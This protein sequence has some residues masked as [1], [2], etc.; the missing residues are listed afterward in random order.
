MG[1]YKSGE[2]VQGAHTW[3]SAG[4]YQI[5]VK[6]Q[7]SLLYETNWSEP[8]SVVIKDRPLD[9]VLL[10]GLI[11]NFHSASEF[12]TFDADL[13]LYVNLIPFEP[14]IFSSREEIIISQEYVGLIVLPYGVIFGFF[15]AAVI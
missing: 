8:E 12:S 2:N 10:L 1:P 15:N 7:D 5:R 6:A 4:L 13:L 14:K 11:S 3:Y 9:T